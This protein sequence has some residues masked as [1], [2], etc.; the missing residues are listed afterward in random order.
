MSVGLTGLVTGIVGIA[1]AYCKQYIF[2]LSISVAFAMLKI[3]YIDQ[4]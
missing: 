3:I 4:Y 1:D 2:L